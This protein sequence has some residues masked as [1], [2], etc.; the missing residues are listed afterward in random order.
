MSVLRDLLDGTRGGGID[1]LDLTAPLS[2]R[3]PILAEETPIAG[4]S[5]VRVP[6]LVER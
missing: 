2:E 1:V 5:P 4:I 3:T 6:A